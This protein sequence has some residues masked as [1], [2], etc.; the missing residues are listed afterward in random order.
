MD[1]NIEDNAVPKL[2]LSEENFKLTNDHCGVCLKQTADAI[3]HINEM[4][5]N[6][7]QDIT[8]YQ[9]LADHVCTHCHL[10]LEKYNEF[11][12]E[13]RQKHEELRC[14]AKLIVKQ[15]D[16]MIIDDSD[17][18]EMV[19]EIFECDNCSYSC[20]NQENLANHIIRSHIKTN[21]KILKPEPEEIYECQ[22]CKRTFNNKVRYNWHLVEH[23]P[24]VINCLLYNEKF[25]SDKN[26]KLKHKN[27]VDPL[28][29]KVITLN[30]ANSK[31]LESTQFESVREPPENLPTKSLKIENVFEVSPSTNTF[32]KYKR[33]E[34]EMVKK[35]KHGP[36]LNVREYISKKR[37]RRNECGICYKKL[38]KKGRLK[39]HMKAFHE[40]GFDCGARCNSETNAFHCETCAACFL[41][42]RSLRVH[43]CNRS[44]N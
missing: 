11:Q 41:S 8:G 19:S 33:I 34:A 23:A 3:C 12:N 9:P 2:H 38:F 1:K 14:K 16:H 15:E 5:S 29:S 30:E 18:N 28:Q 20:F 35:I 13:I 26:L 37:Y 36:K 7:F 4:L 21:N 17:D 24:E 43:A 27:K 44:F 6:I 25:T 22:T 39:K 32:L 10:A 40:N 31:L 42:L